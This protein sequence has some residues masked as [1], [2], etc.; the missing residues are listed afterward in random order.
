M[1]RKNNENENEKEGN[2]TTFLATSFPGSLRRE[3]NT[4]I[5]ETSEHAGSLVTILFVRPCITLCINEIY[6]S[7]ACCFY[8]LNEGARRVSIRF[9]Y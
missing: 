4:F 9:S 5:K 6:M 3:N 7:V 8:K 1:E 2:G